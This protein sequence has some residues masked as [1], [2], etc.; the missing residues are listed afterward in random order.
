MLL[1][2]AAMPAA[3]VI[4]RTLRDERLGRPA[5]LRPPGLGS[6]WLLRDRRRPAWQARERIRNAIHCPAHAACYG[7]HSNEES[8]IECDLA[9]PQKINRTVGTRLGEASSIQAE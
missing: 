5:L 9:T 7:I 4:C 1:R 6:I 3:D 2:T 8:E